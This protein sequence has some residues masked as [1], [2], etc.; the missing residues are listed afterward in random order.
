MRALLVEG[1]EG[2][3]Q[4][5]I[6]SNFLVETAATGERALE[7]TGYTKFDIAVVNLELPD[8]D[9][10][11]LIRRMRDRGF[12]VPVLVL[13][14]YSRHEAKVRA[15]QLGADDFLATPFDRTE[16]LARMNAII[17]RSQRAIRPVLRAG[18][19]EVD[20]QA[21]EVTVDGQPVPMTGR[22]IKVLELLL[23]RKGVTVSKE[24]F[25]AHLYG[26]H[27]VPEIKII[28]VFI[29]KIRRKLADH[30]CP[31]LIHTVRGRGYIIR[32]Q[33]YASL[34]EPE[35]SSIAELDELMPAH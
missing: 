29:C 6:A 14:G 2:I 33:P 22:E 8:I 27:D 31:D 21:H 4:H 5:G 20:P 7:L 28:D 15:L 13:S 34:A 30:G 24:A 11:E 16:L 19:L 18:P 9:G 23:L 35:D 26:G 17:R 12:D 25:L 3:G 10:F 1:A 32:N